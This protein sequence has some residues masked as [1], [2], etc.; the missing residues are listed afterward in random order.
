[1]NK[2][3]GGRRE[4]DAWNFLS[5]GFKKVIFISAEHGDNISQLENEIIS[6][7]DFSIVKD[8]SQEEKPV[9]IALLGKPN[10]GK[11]A[12]S[13]HLTS[14]NASIVCN[15][16]GTTRDVVEGSF[17]WKSRNFKILDTAGIRRKAKVHENIEYYSVNRAIKTIENADI[18]FLIIDAAEGLSDQDKKI[19]SLAHD[20][21]RGII[22]V[23]NKWDLIEQGNPGK[24][25]TEK[26]FRAVCEKI[27]FQ[28]GQMEWAP[29]I[30][31]S[32]LSGKGFNRLLSTAVQMYSQLC[33]Q[34]GTARLN[35]SLE[36]WLE[37]NPP[38]SGAR[39]RFKIKYIV[40]SS[41][42]PVHF[43]LFASQIHAVSET[44][45]SYL[46]NKI[47][48]DLGFSMIPVSLEL[49]ISGKRKREERCKQ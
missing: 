24:Q 14:S 19:A 21:G 33:T 37:T 8:D 15:I 16:P 25:G 39:S 1:V 28:F 22:M 26:I 44:Y 18:V 9:R 2:T 29:I 27:H 17:T 20:R 49:R 7:L 31:V 30:P 6:S 5:Y 12:I 40:Q 35:S 47:R 11:S 38:P 4:S 3:E 42:N 32:A 10:T 34:I 13:N 41:A 23:L 46:R 45:L 43:I 36:R 48:L